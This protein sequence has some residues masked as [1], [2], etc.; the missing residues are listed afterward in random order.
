MKKA[1]LF[2]CASLGFVNVCGAEENGIRFQ[3][4]AGP[5]K[6]EIQNKN[7]RPVNFSDAFLNAAKECSPYSENLV[8][9]NP[10]WRQYGALFGIRDGAVD[11][12]INGRSDGLCSFSVKNSLLGIASVTYRCKLSN[13]QHQELYTAMTDKSTTPVTETF[14]TYATAQSADGSTQKIP[15]EMMM[16]D[17]K[18]NIVWNKLMADACEEQINEPDESVKEKM[19]SFSPEFTDNLKKCVPSDE[20]KQFLL[21]SFAVSVKGFSGGKC[22]I[23]LSPFE[24]YADQSDLAGLDTLENLYDFIENKPDDQVKYIPEYP[25][26]GITQA[27]KACRQ[28]TEKYNGA[29]SSETFGNVIVRKGIQASF[30]DGVCQVKLANLLERRGVKKGYGKICRIP[31]NEL[32]AFIPADDP[33]NK[34]GFSFSINSAEDEEIQ[35]KLLESEWC[36]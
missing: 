23:G 3:L 28:E 16:T 4:N 25:S 13:E 1:V 34:N 17:S 9:T 22:R 7:I 30:K 10:D 11:V 8:D 35:K 2:L 31:R 6:T 5:A 27:L 18:L 15:T 21:L 19:L 33:E 29:K 24:L 20:T 32:D 26:A 12:T 14:T 36:R